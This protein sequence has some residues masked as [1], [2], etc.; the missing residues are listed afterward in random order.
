MLW[1]H[2]GSKGQK[3]LVTS[4]IEGRGEKYLDGSTK[5]TLKA[6]YYWTPVRKNTL[7][8]KQTNTPPHTHTRFNF[9]PLDSTVKELWS[10]QYRSDPTKYQSKPQLN[11]GFIFWV[12]LGLWVYSGPILENLGPLGVYF[13]FT[14]GLLKNCIWGQLYALKNEADMY[15]ILPSYCL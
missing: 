11:P 5:I 9:G 14:M 10:I 7:I 15:F 8:N 13:R 3:N 6:V 1:F 12:T 2:R 4:I